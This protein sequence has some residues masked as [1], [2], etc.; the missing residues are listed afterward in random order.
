MFDPNAV[1]TLDLTLVA[2]IAFDGN[3]HQSE[4]D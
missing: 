3:F 2:R 4:S 1:F